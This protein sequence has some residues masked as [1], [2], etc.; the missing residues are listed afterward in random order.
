MPGQLALSVNEKA[1]A[2]AAVWE[3]LPLTVQRQVTVA[4]ARL[5][6]QLVEAERDE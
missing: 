4:L 6:A 3:T 2:P 5:L 1:I